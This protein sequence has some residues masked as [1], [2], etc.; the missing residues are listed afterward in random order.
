MAAPFRGLGSSDYP[1][2]TSF[3]TATHPT[4]DAPSRNAAPVVASWLFNPAPTGAPVP[5]ATLAAWYAAD[6]LSLADNADVTSW[7]S[8]LG[9]GPPLSEATLTPPKFRTSILNGLPAVRWD[10][11]SGSDRLMATNLN[12]LDGTGGGSIFIVAK[13]NAP[14]ANFQ[15]FV[16]VESGTS[17]RDRLSLYATSTN[18][19]LGLYGRRLDADGLTSKPSTT[20]APSTAAVIRAE[21]NWTAGTYNLLVDGVSIGSGAW[22]SSGSTSSTNSQAFRLGCSNT[23]TYG[24]DGDIYEVLVYES[25]LS[26]TDAAAVESYL[27]TKWGLSGSSATGSLDLS[28]SATA[29]GAATTSGSLSLSG[30]ATWTAP[31]STGALALTA[32]AVVSAAPTASGSVSLSATATA[33]AA[34]TATGSLTL[35]AAATATGTSGTTASAVLALA[36]AATAG[37][38]SSAAATV[39]LAGS[40]A[41]RGAANATAV[42]TLVGSA[43]AGAPSAAAGAVELS[44]AATGAGSDTATA[45]IAITAV[46]LEARANAQA[47]A[48]LSLMGA[49]SAS[50]TGSDS[51]GRITPRPVGTPAITAA[52]VGAPAITARPISGATIAPAAAPGPTITPRP[53]AGTTIRPA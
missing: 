15:T 49:G 51:P 43:S 27:A 42:V 30:S 39:T 37:T 32:S 21:S 26:S 52:A 44:G 53:A 1:P 7:P 33:A 45:F 50:G 17:G 9:F 10:R 23:T 22:T 8:H 36:A 48:L 31:A 12:L 16:A 41:A 14:Q 2:R 20:V 19:Y 34:A 13:S 46:A 29:S 47:L 3:T 38:S 4:G 11:A 25:V 40:A 6:D 18:G 5:T 28:A 24:L 35:D